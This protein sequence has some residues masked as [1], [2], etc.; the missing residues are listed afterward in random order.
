MKVI[1]NVVFWVI[2]LVALVVLFDRYLDEE[3]VFRK[4]R[5]GQGEVYFMGEIT[6]TKIDKAL[7]LLKRG[8][9]LVIDSG[10]GDM[11]SAMR[12]GQY[13]W[14]NNIPIE[15]LDICMSS[16]A[17]YLFLAASEKILNRNSLVVYHG[18]P[19][20][21]NILAQLQSA[22]DTAGNKNDTSRPI[23]RANFEMVIEENNLSQ[24][25]DWL[26]SRSSCP[27]AN[28]IRD[29]FGVCVLFTPE[30][31]LE[32]LINTEAKFYQQISPRLDKNIPYYG[33]WGE[34]ESVYE[35]YRYFGFYY[36]I[37]TLERMGVDNIRV[38]GGEWVP[39]SNPFIS[40][41]YKV[42]LD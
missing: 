33:Q 10:G 9:R 26:L 1:F 28:Y 34:N 42:E 22:F 29:S 4:E 38:N 20:Q 3:D 8:D 36:D 32:D 23:G 13:M 31:Y 19:R 5:Q 16:C 11:A 2:L 12:L 6:P 30:A 40:R 21:K 14:R 39:E 25:V 15:V 41:V 35:A 27:Q 18:G 7:G 24:R 37:D 17:N